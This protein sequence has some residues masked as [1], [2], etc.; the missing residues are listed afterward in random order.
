MSKSIELT[1]EQYAILEEAAAARGKKAEAL[2]A[3][4]ID[5][6]RDPMAHPRYYET[7]DWFRHLGM[8]DEEIQRLDAEIEAEE[9]REAPVDADA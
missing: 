5:E 6:V 7:D 4:W 8:S 2:L 3:E 9:A 1:D